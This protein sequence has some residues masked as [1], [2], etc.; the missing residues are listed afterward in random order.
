MLTPTASPITPEI[1][2]RDGVL[3][4]E[5]VQLP[6][7]AEAVGTPCYVYSSGAIE[8][9][10]RGFEAA[11]RPLGAG[12][13]YAVKANPNQAVIA[14]LARLGAGADV[15]SEGEIRR[16]LQA[17]VA[18]SR[19]VFSGVAK[20]AAEL[21]FALAAGVGQ[22]NVESEAELDLLSR[23][24]ADAGR[25]I[26][27]AIRVNPDVDALTHPKITTGKAENK[28]GLP[29]DQ[30]VSLYRRAV[31]LPG[32]EPSSVALHIGSQL[33]DLTPF[34]AA[35]RRLAVLVAE[36]RGAGIPIRHLDLGGGIGVPYR[37][38]TP[39]DPA[40][41]AAIV[42]R[43][44][45]GLGCEITVEPGRLLVAA[46]GLLLT[47]VLAVKH[48]AARRLILQDGAMNDLIRPTLYEAYHPIYPVA[49]SGDDVR[50][51]SD[52]VGPVCESGDYLATGRDMP[53]VDAGDLLAVGFAGAYGASMS[54]TY[55][56]RP[57]AAEIMVR[58]AS[59]SVVRPRQDWQA[60]IG[61]DILPPWL[62][63]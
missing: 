60:L 6:V 2:Y 56:S 54:S 23:L 16:A 20:T 39:P 21:D 14:T 1:A 50:V 42:G 3:A 37:G 55:N 15:V 36:L 34:E 43:T 19:I 62:A 51:E 18:P 40:D 53:L 35:F 32:L 59:W 46:A 33:L 10:Y 5:G 38:E 47:R 27:I 30:A 12:I 24:A 52:V 41:Y 48:G 13:C 45:G 8:R 58:G 31:D 26:R 57:L 63:P 7:I 49:L 29:I 61:A 22:V 28:F 9:Q 44:V 11:M 4:V 17:G 25:T